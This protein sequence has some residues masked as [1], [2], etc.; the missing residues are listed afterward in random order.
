[1]ILRNPR[2]EVTRLRSGSLFRGLR[3]NSI[4]ESAIDRTDGL[5]VALLVEGKIVL[6]AESLEARMN[7]LVV[8]TGHARPQV[9]LNLVVEVTSD[10]IDNEGRSDILSG[11]DGG[12][13]PI[14]LLLMTIDREHGVVKRENPSEV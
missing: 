13:D 11:G 6:L 12:S 3:L 14:T 10:D 5:E 9:V 7:D 1:M 2:L 8:M 4:G